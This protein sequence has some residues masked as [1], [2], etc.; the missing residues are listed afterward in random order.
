M[1]SVYFAAAA[2][3]PQLNRHPRRSGVGYGLLLW[4]AMYWVILPHRFPTMFPILDLR[5]VGEQLVSHVALVGIPIALVAR[6][7]ARWRG[8]DA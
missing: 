2:L 4:I 6:A 3:I 8:P 7:A 5:E 1:V